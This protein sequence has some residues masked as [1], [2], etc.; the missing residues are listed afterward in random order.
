MIA[1]NNYRTICRGFTHDKNNIGSGARRNDG[2]GG[3]RDERPASRDT[4]RNTNIQ[5]GGK[6]HIV[7]TYNRSSSDGT[8]RSRKAI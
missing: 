5:S 7:E 8:K 1:A 3:R 4:V 6:G 2:K